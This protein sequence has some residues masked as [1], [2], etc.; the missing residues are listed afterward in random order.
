MDKESKIG[1]MRIK[2]YSSG[3]KVKQYY[4]ACEDCGNGRWQ[5]KGISNRK[6]YCR[7]CALKREFANNPNHKKAILL[8]SKKRWDREGER[9]RMSNNMKGSKN[10]FYGKTHTKRVLTIMSKPRT[11]IHVKPIMDWGYLIGIVLGDGWLKE[12]KGSYVVGVSSTRPEIVK[13]Y[14]EV[15]KSLGLHSGYYC[16][17][18]KD[19][20]FYCSEVCSKEL[21]NYL[22]PCKSEDFHFHVPKIIYKNKSMMYGFLRGFFD[23]EGGVYKTNSGDSTMSISC[24]SKHISSLVQI[25]DLLKIGGIQS[26]LHKEN[27]KNQISARL[28][29]SDYENRL[30]FSNLVGFRI[31]RKQKQLDNMEKPF[32]ERYAKEQYEWAMELRRK[33]Y[34]YPEIQKITGVN[35]NTVAV[36]YHKKKKGMSSMIRAERQ[37]HK[38]SENDKELSHLGS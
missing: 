18:N 21:Y 26:Y 16:V 36:W 27:K 7:S 5:V 14:H 35:K 23:A 38:I 15:C 32:G 10:H 33:G 24:W 34:Q 29:I 28:N 22:R 4:M 13:K 31:H 1:D 19:K 3:A 30:L 2:E 9:E 11:I 25:R 8:G 20:S 12:R 37:N 6:K 17:K